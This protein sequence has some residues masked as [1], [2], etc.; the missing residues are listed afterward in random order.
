MLLLQVDLAR[1]ALN[2]AQKINPESA[3]IWCV[4]VSSKRLCAEWHLCQADILSP[5]LN[6]KAFM[7]FTLTK[8]KLVVFQSLIFFFFEGGEG[9]GKGKTG[10][11][12]PL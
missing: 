3:E 8:T 9:D 2:I 5:Y 6:E 7:S 11:Y 1:Q 12:P 4:L 10:T